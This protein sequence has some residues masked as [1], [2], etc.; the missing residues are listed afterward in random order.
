MLYRPVV[1][2]SLRSTDGRR[3]MQRTIE[4]SEALQ[5]GLFMSDS[6]FVE[7]QE[8]AEFEQEWNWIE[9]AG[10]QADHTAGITWPGSGINE[11]RD[12]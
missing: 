7:L 8:L 9:N 12:G 11:C 2:F 1:G 5:N 4:Q 6:V 3:V 10:G